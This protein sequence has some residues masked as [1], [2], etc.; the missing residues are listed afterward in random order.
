MTL[1]RWL[2]PLSSGTTATIT[3]DAGLA[4]PSVLL[5][6]PRGPIGGSARVLSGL[7]AVQLGMAFTD[8]SRVAAELRVKQESRRRKRG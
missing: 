8:A 1:P 3:I 2:V 4:D 6:V 7:D 5:D